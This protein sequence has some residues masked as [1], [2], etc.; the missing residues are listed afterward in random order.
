[1]I[2]DGVDLRGLKPQMALAYCIAQAVYAR[3]NYDCWITSASDGKHG[4]DSLHYSGCGL[5][6][7]TRHLRAESVHL[8]YSEL[9]AAL[10]KQFDVVLEDDHIHVEFDPK[11]SEPDRES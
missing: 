8:V 7:R 6:L 1:M 10:G 11:E 5:D 9:R 4:P 3:R 2:T